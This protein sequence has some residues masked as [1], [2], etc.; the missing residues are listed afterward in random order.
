MKG[1]VETLI[2]R[3]LE[4]PWKYSMIHSLSG[5]IWTICSQ[6]LNACFQMNCELWY[7][8]HILCRRFI[9]EWFITN[10]INCLWQPLC[11]SMRIQ[12]D[13]ISAQT[14]LLQSPMRTLFLGKSAGPLQLNHFEI[15]HPNLSESF[16]HVVMTASKLPR[17]S[18]EPTLQSSLN[19]LHTKHAA[20]NLM[21][22]HI[23]L[24]CFSWLHVVFW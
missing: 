15:H 1:F 14:N 21:N 12:I 2:Y 18:S 9:I 20:I 3:Y 5:V 13:T 22:A 17:N 23:K 19:Q 11:L 4:Q 16:H 24:I 6:H 7:P 8:V 10:V